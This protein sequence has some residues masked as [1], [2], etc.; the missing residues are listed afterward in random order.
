[1][2]EYPT[3]DE[4]GGY[5]A[6]GSGGGGGE[7]AENC[8]WCLQILVGE[9]GVQEIGKLEEGSASAWPA[10]DFPDVRPNENDKSCVFG[11]IHLLTG[12]NFLPTMPALSFQKE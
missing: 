9:K 6:S 1:M 11:L 10:A 8:G 4:H 5:Q 2:D 12:R 3:I 7:R